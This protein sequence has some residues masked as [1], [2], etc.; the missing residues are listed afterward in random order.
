MTVSALN[1][2]SD[3]D[4][5]EGMISFKGADAF[6]EHQFTV[7]ILIKENYAKIT[8]AYKDSIRH[9]DVRKDLTYSK[10]SLERHK[11]KVDEPKPE[12]ILDSTAKILEKHSAYSRDSTIV[13]L[14][15]D[16]EYADLLECFSNASR[17]DLAPKIKRNWFDGYTVDIS[18]AN[19]QKNLNVFADTP[20]SSNHPLLIN[21][22]SNTLKKR[23][24]SIPVEK[25]LGYYLE[26]Q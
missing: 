25:I 14:E 4:K 21:M 7:R 15:N 18:V 26:L 17:D 1:A 6:G 2:Q 10:L 20:N 12:W 8:Y 19:N 23:K 3:M 22:L 13:N 16:K 5:A 11:Y 24:D 9:S